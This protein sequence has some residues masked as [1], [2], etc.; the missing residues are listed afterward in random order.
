MRVQ[1]WGGLTRLDA[2][3]HAPPRR[4]RQPPIFHISF[5]PYCGAHGILA[6]ALVALKQ[7]TPDSEVTLLGT[8]K[9]RVGQLPGAYAA[10]ALVVGLVTRSLLGTV[11]AVLGGAYL[12]WLY[13]RYGQA[14]PG[15]ELR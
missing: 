2:V 7:V 8:I 14:R 5:S 6:A 4:A 12:G 15:L 10:A 1:G 9:F 13:L 3:S 11:P